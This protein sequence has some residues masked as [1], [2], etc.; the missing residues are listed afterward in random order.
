MLM[1]CGLIDFPP[2]KVQSVTDWQRAGVG[3]GVVH[4]EVL[5]GIRAAEEGGRRCPNFFHASSKVISETQQII[6]PRSTLCGS[7]YLT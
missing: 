1:S 2:G 3:N 4:V 6:F 5:R 7:E